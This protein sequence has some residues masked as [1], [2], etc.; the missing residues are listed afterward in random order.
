MKIIDLLKTV[1]VVLL[2]SSLI[3]NWYLLT[4]KPEVE[5]K[6][7]IEYVEKLDTITEVVPQLVSKTFIKTKY[8]T[9]LVKEYIGDTVVAEVPIEQKVFEKDSVY[10][11]W[12]TGYDVNLDSIRI[13]YKTTEITER[14]DHYIK[15]DKRFGIG[16]VIYGGYSPSN[17]K[18]DWGIGIGVTYQILR[19]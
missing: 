4:K 5:T 19:W 13:F 9:L 2:V 1:I 17:K 16:P 18:L 10:R 12:V 15:E 7:R 3:L 8:D 6:T 14:I 11:A